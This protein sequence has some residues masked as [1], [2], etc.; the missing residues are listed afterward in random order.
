M[1]GDVHIDVAFVAAPS[2]DCYGNINGTAGKSA[3]GSMGYAM[4]D[5]QYADCVVAVTDNLVAYPNSPVSIDQTHADFVVAVDSIGDP[6]GIVS[7][8]TKVTPTVG[9]PTGMP[10]GMTVTV[11]A[12]SD[13]EIPL[14]ITIAA[15]S[16]L[17]AAGQLNGVVNVPVSAPVDTTL[18]IHW[19]KVKTLVT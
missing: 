8:T 3:C 7:G 14:T 5:C 11:G 10:T 13:N 18:Q 15:N 6:A 4:T 9:T 1:S 19:S 12:A 2:C 17:G 16:T